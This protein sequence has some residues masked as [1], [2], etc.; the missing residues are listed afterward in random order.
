MSEQ[1]SSKDILRLKWLLGNGLAVLALWSAISLSIT[2]LPLIVAS[3]LVIS[4]CIFKPRIPGKWVMPNM[5]IIVG[6]IIAFALI[7]FLFSGVNF[8]A[9]LIR[10]VIF[11]L[12][13]RACSYRTRREDMQIL[14]LSLFL[15]VLTGVLTVSLLFGAQ[16]LVFTP[17]SMVFL[18]FVNLA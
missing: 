3:I 10:L 12:L 4:L 7:D 15:M 17:L 18:F 1:L 11:L 5:Q 8:L 13:V 6:C 9:P 2:S 16:M 14:L